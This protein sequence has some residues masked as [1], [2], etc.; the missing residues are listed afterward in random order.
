LGSRVLIR[1][2]VVPKLALPRGGGGRGA[3][4]VVPKNC[5]RLP[6]HIVGDWDKRQLLL[7]KC[8]KKQSV[9]IRGTTPLR[10]ANMGAVVVTGAH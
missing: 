5:G 4:A 6:G 3:P 1:V 2:P 7:K 10:S 9:N 8:R